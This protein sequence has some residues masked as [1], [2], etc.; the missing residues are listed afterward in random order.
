MWEAR[1]SIAIRRI[2]DRKSTCSP[3]RAK[4]YPGKPLNLFN[5]SRISLRSIRAT[6]LEDLRARAFPIHA[7]LV[8]IFPAVNWTN[9]R[10][11]SIEIRSPNSVLLAIVVDPFPKKVGRNPSFSTCRAFGAHDIGRKPVA[12]ATAPAAAMI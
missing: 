3:D 8:D 5:C 11:I 7:A 9:V 4:R 10:G 12:I 6:E 1:R 2:G